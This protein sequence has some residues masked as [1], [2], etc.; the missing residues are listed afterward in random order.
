[1]RRLYSIGALTLDPHRQLLDGSRPLPI[2]GKALDI[3]SVLAAAGG[4]LVTKSELLET[5][6]RAVIVEENAIQVHVSAARRALGTEAGR[7]TTVWGS[8]YRLDAVPLA[9]GDAADD[10]VRPSDPDDPEAVMLVTQARALAGRVTPE[11]VLRSIDLHER[12]IARAPG[13]APAWTGLAGTLMVATVTGALPPARRASARAMVEQAIRMDTGSG[14]P[15]AI[16]AVLDAGECR[17]LDAAAGFHAATARSPD[18]PIAQ[19]AAVL[20]LWGP[21]GHLGHA[22]ALIDAAVRAD[23][24]SVNLALSRAY[25]AMLAGDMATAVAQLENAS[26]LGADAT[27][28]AALTLRAELALATTGLDVAAAAVAAL[29][30][31]VAPPGLDVTEAAGCIAAALTGPGDAASASRAITRFADAAGLDHG[32]D[33]AQL[34]LGQLIGWQVRLGALDGAYAL[35]GR[36]VAIGERS[37]CVAVRALHF[38][39]RDDMRSFRDNARFAALADRFG[40]PD[41]WRRLGPPDA[42]P[43]GDRRST[44]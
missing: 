35:A 31:S 42:M 44:S 24:A 2:G 3:L 30:A 22:A 16:R 41:A 9:P 13:Y 21:I 8:G 38:W 20:H 14:A 18:L 43:A 27:R 6:W 36:L 29:L 23:P 37:G 10:A 34:L 11:A 17:W 33:R 4:R 7:L 12:A 32:A 39:W 19:E 5:I 40:L 28:S 1:M 26:L 25:V 15:H